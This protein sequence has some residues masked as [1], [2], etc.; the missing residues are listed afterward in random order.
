MKAGDRVLI[1]PPHPAR[2]RTGTV[3]ESFVPT[4]LPGQLW[5]SVEVDGMCGH[6]VGG[7]AHEFQVL[8]EP[9]RRRRRRQ[10]EK[11]GG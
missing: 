3:V 8:T 7:R 6:K 4:L 5:W 1:L 10:L 9:T 11:G 2:N